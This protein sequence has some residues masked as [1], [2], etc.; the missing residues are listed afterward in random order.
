MSE[1]RDGGPRRP[2]LE[3]PITITFDATD[4]LAGQHLA[5]L[6]ILTDTPYKVP[7]VRVDLTVRFLDV[8]DG[9]LFDPSIY[10]AAGAGV[11]PGCDPAAFLFC[12]TDLVTRA[13]MAGFILRA[14]HGAD[15]VPA[16]YAGAFA[17]VGRGTT[18][19]TTSN[20]SS[21]R[22]TR[23]DAEEGTTVRARCTRAV[24]RRYSS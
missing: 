8:E 15:F 12:P 6:K 21:T 13:D 7:P 9:S 3:V 14:V 17:D 5:Q 10:A 19:R 24:R 20:R 23:R 2:E 16:P 4:L 22:D 1:S 11:M 18:T